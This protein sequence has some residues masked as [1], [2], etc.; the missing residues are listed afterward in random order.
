MDFIKAHYKKVLIILFCL[1]FFNFCTKSCSRGNEI[2]SL[3]IELDSCKNENIKCHDSIV[4]LNVLLNNKEIELNSK[5]E[6]IKQLNKTITTV[7]NKNAVNH[8][9][10]I[11][12]EKENNTKS[13]E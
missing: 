9:R 5:N 1:L 10:V 11:V 12:P 6:Q 2:N 7:V 13:N 8:I 3:R 4:Q